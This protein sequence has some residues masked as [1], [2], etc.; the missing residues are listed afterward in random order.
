MT[1]DTATTWLFDLD[2]CL[3]DSMG[4]T[5]L[6]PHARELLEALLGLGITV[7]IW[8]AG[9]DDYANRVAERVGIADLVAGY[10]TKVRQP[11]GTWALPDVVGRATE[12]SVVC[13]DDQPD[14]VPGHVTTIAVFPFIG[15]RPHDRA[16]ARLLDELTAA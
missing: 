4:G 9:G 7:R 13:V 6:R 2:G 14:G 3:V 5:I 15:A 10:H 16:F 8:S 12:R 1:D 11:S